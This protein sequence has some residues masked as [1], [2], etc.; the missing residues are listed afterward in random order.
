MMDPS[1]KK[2][3][4][5]RE[6]YDYFVTKNFRIISARG[7]DGVKYPDPLP[8]DGYGDQEQKRPEVFAFDPVEGCHIV[9]VTRCEQSELSS[10]SSLTEYNV[11]LDQIDPQTQKP[12]R[13]YV[14]MP[15]SL[16]GEFNALMLEYIHREYWYKIV[17]MSSQRV[18]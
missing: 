10:E 9:G 7:I 4:L 2:T 17:V 6:L 3:I 15:A 5:I 12:Y 13:L 16:V 11:F 1:D 18:S 8:N 14:N